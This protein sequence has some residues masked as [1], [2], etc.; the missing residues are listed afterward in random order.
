MTPEQFDREIKYRLA[1]SVAKRM[2]EQNLITNE[3]YKI[4][5]IHFATVFQPF[6]GHLAA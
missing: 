4:M 1:V 2:V 5:D 3:E 6:F